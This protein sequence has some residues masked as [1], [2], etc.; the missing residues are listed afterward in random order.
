M[1]KTR[2]DAAKH[3]FHQGKQY[4]NTGRW[5]K[6][7]A[8]FTDAIALNLNFIQA[9][10][11]RAECLMRLQQW[12]KAEHDMNA[13][14]ASG[15][16]P[17]NR[18]I[19]RLTAILSYKGQTDKACD[20]INEYTK[21]W[22]R[23]NKETLKPGPIILTAAAP[24]TASTS[25]SVALAKAADCPK[26]NFLCYQRAELGK[27]LPS[28]QALKS[29]RG[30]GVVNHCHLDCNPEFLQTLAAL[31]YV[32]VV[33]HMRN[34]LDTLTSTVDMFMRIKSPIILSAKPELATAP[35]N[36]LKEWAIAVYLPHL[37]NWME[38]WLRTVD[39]QHPSVLGLSTFDQIK[40]KGQD[41]VARELLQTA[42]VKKI[43]T[44]ETEPQ[45]T[46]N[47]LSGAEKISF[48]NK[49]KARI[50]AEIPNTL[51]DRFAW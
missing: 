28:L 22:I 21:T 50:L 13:V 33:V 20:Q 38:G 31:A 40:A 18:D 41:Q 25:L 8:G 39:N 15:I 47:R 36:Q 9:R 26:I 14:I 27:G 19:K 7:V 34:P 10:R 3:K 35:L 51:R 45:R 42:N 17:N 43:V 12:D 6:A 30:Y 37:I 2:N 46:G 23:E 48:S 32:K 16:Q 11:R 1:I 4:E 24:K 29:L 49:Q 44:A 5:Q